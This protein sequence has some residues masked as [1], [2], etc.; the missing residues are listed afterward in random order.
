VISEDFLRYHALFVESLRSE[1]TKA[2]QEQ[3]RAEMLD[4]CIK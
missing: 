4:A 2:F 3:E 1:V